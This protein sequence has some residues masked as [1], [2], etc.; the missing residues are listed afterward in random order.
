M[1]IYLI[2]GVVVV[3]LIASMW[4]DNRSLWNPALL[5]IVCVFWIFI[6]SSSGISIWKRGRP[7]SRVN[8]WIFRSAL[9]NLLEW[10]FLYL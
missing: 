4:R 2:T 7:S 8:D 3:A 6:S 9:C 1:G 10:L 5:I